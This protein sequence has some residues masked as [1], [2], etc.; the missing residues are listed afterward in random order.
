MEVELWKCIVSPVVQAYVP[1]RFHFCNNDQN[2]KNTDFLFSQ[3]IKFG[4]FVKYHLFQQRVPY[5]N[6]YFFL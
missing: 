5:E 6:F 2:V 4:V 1:N 3:N